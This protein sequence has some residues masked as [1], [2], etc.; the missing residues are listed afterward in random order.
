VAGVNGL[1]THGW[2][3]LI[4]TNAL[5]VGLAVAITCVVGEI[6]K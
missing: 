4:T 5:V 2:R 3:M 6:R 1:G